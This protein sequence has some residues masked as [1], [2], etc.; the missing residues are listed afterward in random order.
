MA[1]KGTCLVEG[2]DR[3]A[4]S[5]GFCKAHYQRRLRGKEILTPIN[6]RPGAS[7]RKTCAVEGCDKF[8]V[9]VGMCNAHYQR[10][11][12]GTLG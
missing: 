4:H 2:C 12:R 10:S 7:V 9:S 5:R 8:A 1:D 11:R 3:A 6:P